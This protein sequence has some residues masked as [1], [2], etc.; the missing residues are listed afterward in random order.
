MNIRKISN[1]LGEV[2]QV[3]FRKNNLSTSEICVIVN[4]SNPRHQFHNSKTVR[5]SSRIYII[6]LK[7][8]K[9]LSME[10]SEEP[11]F[12]SSEEETL[13]SPSE[14]RNT[15]EAEK[16]PSKTGEESNKTQILEI[17]GNTQEVDMDNAHT[18]N[19]NNEEDGEDL[20]NRVEKENKVDIE[21]SLELPVVNDMRMN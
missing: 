18:L 11:L 19:L 16:S 17:Q 12:I 13:E 8:L 9:A 5:D 4:H 2:H 1:N 15:D 20:E 21:D 14:N 6:L 7:E 3:H 10:E